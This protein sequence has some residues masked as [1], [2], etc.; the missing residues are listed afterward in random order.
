MQK[1]KAD[2]LRSKG[3]SHQ[4]A[5]VVA[6]QNTTV[7]PLKRKIP[8]GINIL[9]ELDQ[10]ML[11]Q[12]CYNWLRGCRHFSQV[13]LSM[14]ADAH[15]FPIREEKIVDFP[16]SDLNP[17]WTTHPEGKR[18]IARLMADVLKKRKIL[19]VEARKDGLYVGVDTSNKFAP[20]RPATKADVDEVREAL[21]EDQ[22]E[23]VDPDTLELPFG[24][25][26]AIWNEHWEPNIEFLPVRKHQYG[27]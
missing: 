1:T 4:Q 5:I 26:D 2:I 17:I 27:R 12:A 21:M 9:S 25:G 24:V 19:Y 23:S 13:R 8:G 3:V 10:T 6:L 22:D 18:Y 15:V 20:T 16:E 14:A 11:E 7:Q